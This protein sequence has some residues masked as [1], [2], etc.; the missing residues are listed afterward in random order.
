MRI[1][2]A[3]E[4]EQKGFFD[5]AFYLSGYAV[6]CALKAIL[7]KRFAA[8]ELPDNKFVADIYTHDLVKLLRLSG[9]DS[10]LTRQIPKLQE[11]WQAIL[12]WTE[13]ARYKNWTQA[14]ARDMIRAVGDP[15][16]G[17]LQWLQSKW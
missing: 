13:Q 9:L 4:L 6:E 16:E 17:V 3:A 11:N 8:D 7:C 5:G 15:S 14:E 1:R 12:G 10:D 2:E